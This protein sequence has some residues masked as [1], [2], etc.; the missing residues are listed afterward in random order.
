MTQPDFSTIDLS[1]DSNGIAICAFNRPDVRNALSLAMVNEIHSMLNYLMTSDS[2]RVLIFTGHGNTFV[3]GAD[4]DEMVSRKRIDALQKINNGLFCAIE[5]FPL[6]TIASIEGYALGGGCELAASCDLRVASADAKLGQPEVKL[7]IIPGA[8]ATYRLPKLIGI[9][10]TKDLVYTGRIVTASAALEMGLVNRVT[11]EDPLDVAREIA[12][13]IVRNS[14]AAV[15]FA[16]M[17][18][19]ASSEMSTAGGVA[20]ETAIQSVLYED[21][22]KYRR[23][24]AF[25]D[26]RKKK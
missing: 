7:G 25:L 2:A 5:D 17:A 8:G 4:I 11:E 18:I 16:K 3:S 14:A 12:D 9:A 22:E 10:R 13:Q 23:M 20:L 19:N 26:R 1:I 21:D 24:Q 6:P 15:Q